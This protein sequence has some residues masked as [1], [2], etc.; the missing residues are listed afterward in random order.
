MKKLFSRKILLIIVVLFSVL[1][2][3]TEMSY[4]IQA[5]GL[6]YKEVG[7]QI[8]FTGR[9]FTKDIDGVKHYVTVND[10][11]E[12]YFKVSG[13]K[14]VFV[15]FTVI[16]SYKTPY[17]SY[18]IDGGQPIRQLITNSEISF[19]DTNEHIVRIIIAG[20]AEKE[21]KWNGEI[22][23]AL[24]S[25]EVEQ[26][27]IEGVVPINK[28]IAFYGDSITEGIRA[29]QRSS[30]S[31]GNSATNSYAWYACREL[32]AVPYIVGFGGT[33]IKSVGS[34]NTCINTIDWY[35]ATR[36]SDDYYADII[37]LN[38]GTNDAK[39]ESDEFIGGYNNILNRLHEKHPN[40]KIV[41]MIPFNQTHADDIRKCVSDKNDWCYLIETSEWNLTYTDGIHPDINGAESAGVNLSKEL[42][43][44]YGE[45]YFES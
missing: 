4:A 42:I 22:G 27:V 17:F 25:V 32:N 36:E 38:H 16:T 37:V 2:N 35:S 18:S 11:S 23:V 14:S 31:D 45:N 5:K 6:S 13:A 8:G 39:V 33:G 29:L 43:N 21:D 3:M 20:M 9:W 1:S 7:D 40:A 41:C 19:D 10:G 26:G 24:R 15:N 28:V 12:F 34:F 44:L 30:D